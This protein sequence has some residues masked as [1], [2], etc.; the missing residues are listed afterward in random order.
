MLFFIFN[1]LHDREEG[2][3]CLR[4]AGVQSVVSSGAD[5]NY[6]RRIGMAF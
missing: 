2:R 6:I 5:S 4:E 1:V 3:R